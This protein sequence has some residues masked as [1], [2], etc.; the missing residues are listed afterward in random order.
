[1]TMNE[2]INAVTELIE[3]CKAEDG[4]SLVAEAWRKLCHSLPDDL[5]WP[6]RRRT[7]WRRTRYGDCNANGINKTVG[8]IP[9]I[10]SGDV[11]SGREIVGGQNGGSYTYDADADDCLCFAS[12]GAIYEVR[13]IDGSWS[14]WQG[15]SSSYS[16][17]WQVYDGPIEDFVFAEVLSEVKSL[18]EE[19]REERKAKRKAGAKTAKALIDALGSIEAK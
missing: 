6:N 7:G 18:L 13:D 2:K 3:S 5:K 8:D 11:D 15:S 16:Y 10:Y 4:R 12:D 19:Y 9:C 17:Q 14:Q 1:M